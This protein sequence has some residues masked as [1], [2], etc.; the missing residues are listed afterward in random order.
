M[1][2]KKSQLLNTSILVV[3]SLFIVMYI[4]GMVYASVNTNKPKQAASQTTT[5][6]SQQNGDNTSQKI[7]LPNITP[8][9]P[10]DTSTSS[11]DQNAQTTLQNNKHRE[12]EDD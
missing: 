4:S 3:A 11:A 6:T 12:R 5:Q 9:I 10:L 8:D 7:Q 1:V 2:D